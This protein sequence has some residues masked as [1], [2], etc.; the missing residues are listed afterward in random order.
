KVYHYSDS[1]RYG[2]TKAG[3]YMCEKDTVSAGFRTAGE[4]TKQAPMARTQPDSAAETRTQPSAKPSPR[5]TGNAAAAQFSTVLAAKAHC[6]T[7]T[8][9]WA[10]TDSKI[11][12]YSD[13][14]RYGK[15][16]DGAYMCEKDTAP[17]GF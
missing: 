7:D 4:A 8:V 6:P 10:N 2:K 16:K 11:Y 1:A 5:P 14:A 13:S 9:V 15:T 17:A 12:H 3:A